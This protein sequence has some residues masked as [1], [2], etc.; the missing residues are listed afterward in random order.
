M[1]SV[2]EDPSNLTSFVGKVTVLVGCRI[3]AIGG[4]VDVVVVAVVDTEVAVVNV[5][6]VLAVVVEGVVVVVVVIV[7]TTSVAVVVSDKPLSSVTVKR[8]V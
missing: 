7:R 1:S 8:I 3:T 2:E 5:V 6:V 4:E